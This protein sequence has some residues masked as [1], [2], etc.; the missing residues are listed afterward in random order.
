MRE[1]R[2]LPSA[3]DP[4][5]DTFT[6]AGD[7]IAWTESTGQRPPQIWAVNLR[8]GK[9]ARRLT[10]DTGNA[11]FYGNQYDL[12]IADGRVHWT[13][14]PR[15]AVT[16]IRSVPLTGGR[17]Q[18]HRESGQWALSAW[19]WLTDDTGDQSG[20]TKLRDLRTGRTV[21]VA[22]TGAD[23]TTCSPTW[24]R[25]MV[26]GGQGLIR[27]DLMRP[28]G[29]ARRRIGGGNTQIAVTDVAVLD[30]FEILSEP[31]PDTDLTGTAGLLVYDIRTGRTV[32]VS[33][34]ADG[35]FTRGG[36]LWWST[37]DAE[38]TLWHSLDLRGA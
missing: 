3:A 38:D 6:T 31:G 26:T 28:D 19:P 10:A 16:E 25:V 13:A 23:P 7:D 20:T 15:T 17:V 12:V 1:L 27:V 36:L 22:A 37:G 4:Q 8:D 29:T 33:P 5:F 32:V 24:C 21:A 34:A 18:V 9:P 35:A 11:V 2:R 30:R 14:A